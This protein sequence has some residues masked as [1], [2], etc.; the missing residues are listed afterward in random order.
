MYAARDLTGESWARIAQAF[1][2][3]DHTTI[4]HAYQQISRR[5]SHDPQLRARIEAIRR[6]LTCQ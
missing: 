6:R 3:N 1:G 4:L 2:R 5:L